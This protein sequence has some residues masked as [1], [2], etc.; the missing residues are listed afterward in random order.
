MSE[1]EGTSEFPVAPGPSYIATD[2]LRGWFCPDCGQ[3]LVS[4]IRGG[5]RYP[6]CIRC[7]FVRY[8]N[9]IVGVAVVLRDA[10]GRVLL[11]RR[12]R[13]EYAGLWCVPCGYVEW[14]E[15]VREA[16]I[17]EFREETGLVVELGNVVAVHSNFHNR[18]QHTVG[19]WFAGT[20][21]GGVLH[22]VDNELDALEYYHPTE[23]PPLAFPT[24]A[25]VLR[26]LGTDFA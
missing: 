13:G 14:E 17:R 20:A 18:M 22:P 25:I 2:R 11:G 12:T 10:G 3:A 24:D 23:P 1:T 15:D 5:H 7:G 21:I 4:D 6:H 26:D 9:P 16:A 19:I 8:R